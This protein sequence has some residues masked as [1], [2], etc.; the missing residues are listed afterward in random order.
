MSYFEADGKTYFPFGKGSGE[1]IQNDF[2]LP[3]LIQMPIVADL[4]AAGDGG[5]PLVV[6]DPTCA[7]SSQFMELGAAV[8]REVAKMDN[9]I[10]WEDG[11]N[12][13]ASFE[14][15]DRLREK[16]VPRRG[17]VVADLGDGL[18]QIPVL[19]AN[20]GAARSYQSIP[21]DEHQTAESTTP[22]ALL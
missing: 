15:L 22:S 17:V 1:R 5:K 2:G 16:S 14:L 19:E 20:G 6:A 3:N 13:V 21:A 4:S 10:T 7:T 12:Q 18:R 9:Q 8:V 11:F